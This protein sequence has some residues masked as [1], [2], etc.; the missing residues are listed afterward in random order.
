MT[1]PPRDRFAAA[2]PADNLDDWSDIA[3]LAG[4]GGDMDG[5]PALP[6]EGWVD[7]MVGGLDATERATV[8]PRHRAGMGRARRIALAVVIGSGLVMGARAVNSLRADGSAVQEAPATGRRAAQP[9]GSEFGSSLTAAVRREVS[10]VASQL[11]ST[12]A[13]RGAEEAEHR[14]LTEMVRAGDGVPDL[15]G[16]IIIDMMQ[17]RLE[18][19]EGL[20]AAQLSL[21]YWKVDGMSRTVERQFVQRSQEGGRTRRQAVTEHVPVSL[22]PN[23][24]RALLALYEYSLA[25]AVATGDD[26]IKA[27]LQFRIREEAQTLAAGRNRAPLTRLSPAHL[28]T[29]AATARAMEDAPVP[30]GFSAEFSR[31]YQAGM[32]AARRAALGLLP[33]APRPARTQ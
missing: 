14:F 30:K 9:S 20:S 29:L 33:E 5:A 7:E 19:G 11:G 18:R 31:G 12:E 21:A 28:A 23:H 26:E 1:T 3:P 4:A 27:P 22:D 24:A 13:R 10:L 16:G 6:L 8:S 17:R 32:K 2:D 25:E 15:Q